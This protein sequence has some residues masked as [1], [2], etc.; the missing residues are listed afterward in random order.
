M[1]QFVGKI[2]ILSD[3]GFL[4]KC[5]DGRTVDVKVTSKDIIS[6]I[7][8][9]DHVRVDGDWPGKLGKVEPKFFCARHISV[10]KE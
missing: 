4:L 2:E 3:S 5:E 9:D 10:V 7:N 8:K 1:S 6:S